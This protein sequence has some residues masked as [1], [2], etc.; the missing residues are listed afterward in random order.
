MKIIIGLGNPGKKYEKNR[1]NVGWRIV[2]ALRQKLEFDDWKEASKHKAMISEGTF[3]G[4]KIILAKPQTF[5]NLSGQ[6]VAGLVTFYKI[7]TSNDLLITYD[8]KD[9]LFGKLRERYEGSSGGHNGIKSIV[10]N[11]GT[12]NF[13]RL[14]F[15]VGHEDQKIATDAF[16]LQDFSEEEEAELPDIIAEA[17]NLIVGRI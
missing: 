9:M 7:D 15:G 13:P 4:E 12:E 17:V 8:D 1:H 10:A 2:D 11:I 14:K 16:V 3:N 5:M 6:S